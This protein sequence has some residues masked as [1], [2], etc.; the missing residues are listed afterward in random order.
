HADDAAKRLAPEVRRKKWQQPL[1][2]Q[3][4]RECEEKSRAHA[5]SFL[6]RGGLL[7]PRILQVAKEIGIR[8][9]QQQVAL[10]A[11]ARAVRLHRAVER[12]ELGVLRERLRVGR[13]R[14][15]VALALDALRV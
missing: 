5:P 3:H 9:E 11:K 6:F 7:A 8:L 2:D 1:D 15:G 14:L 12:V 13:R 10:A 4:Q